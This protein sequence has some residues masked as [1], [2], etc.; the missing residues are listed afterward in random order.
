MCDF[1]LKEDCENHKWW[2]RWKSYRLLGRLIAILNR[3]SSVSPGM[4]FSGLISNNLLMSNMY[5]DCGLD[6]R[7]IWY[8]LKLIENE[9]L[10]FLELLVNNFIEF[11]LSLT[12]PIKALPYFIDF[13][14]STVELMLFVSQTSCEIN[15][16]ARCISDVS[17]FRR[18]LIMCYATAE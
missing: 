16:F 7:L 3:S 2:I 17:S 10:L 4:T 6:G 5:L 15:F 11:L 14:W 8:K 13:W 9:R 18:L 12:T 1:Y